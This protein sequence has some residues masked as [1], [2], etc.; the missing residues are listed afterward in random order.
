MEEEKKKPFTFIEI[1]NDSTD[2][3]AYCDPIT[4]ICGSAA[5]NPKEKKQNEVGKKYE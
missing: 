2:E 3:G 5:K 4:G 1:V